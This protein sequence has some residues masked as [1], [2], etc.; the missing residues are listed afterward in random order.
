MRNPLLPRLGIVVAL[1]LAATITLRGGAC[2]QPKLRVGT[3]NIERFGDKGK[4]TDLARLADLIDQTDADVLAVQEMMKPSDVKRLMPMISRRGKRFEFELTKCGGRSKMQ[5]GF[6]YDAER[7]KVSATREYQ[8][9]A[10]DPSDRCEVER[11]G[12]S[13]KF[14]RVDGSGEPFQ[15]LVFHLAAKPE[16]AQQ[17]REQWK[18]AHAIAKKLGEATP[19]AILGDANSTGF[20]DDEGGERTFIEDEARKAKLD[21]VT[22]SLGCSEYYRLKS[23]DPLR[24]SLLDHVVATRGLAR[25][26]S[27]KLHGYCAELACRAPTTDPKDYETVSDHCPVTFDL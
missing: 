16:K 5:L 24:P 1:G 2:F 14:E 10:P 7:V 8:D 25:W 13:A 12:M 17:R 4:D 26:R 18:R 3:F 9:L 22:G 11:P 15:L 23:E 21:I 19:V 27:V 20:L 6:F